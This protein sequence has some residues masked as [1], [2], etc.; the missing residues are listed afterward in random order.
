MTRHFA[1]AVEHRALVK[2]Q[3]GRGDGAFE[4]GTRQ[5][6]NFLARRDLT[7]DGTGDRDFRRRDTGSNQRALRDYDFV[8]ANLAF[9][10]TLDQGGSLEVELA[11]NLGAFA[12]VGLVSA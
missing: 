9:G 11:G 2:D 3:A 1:V 12:D 5:Y 7:V 10:L 8:A 4:A 6:F